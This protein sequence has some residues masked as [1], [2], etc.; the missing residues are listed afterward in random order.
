MPPR[1]RWHIPLARSVV[2][3]FI[4]SSYYELFLAELFPQV[5]IPS[6]GAADRTESYGHLGRGSL[7]VAN[8]SDDGAGSEEKDMRGVRGKIDANEDDWGV[9]FRQTSLDEIKGN[10][11]ILERRI[12]EAVEAA[13]KVAED[14]AAAAA[15]A[16]VAEAAAGT[17]GGEQVSTVS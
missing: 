17:G 4:Q 15:E 13:R 2:P 11:E 8:P 6:S 16:A 3:K 9:R 5:G 7:F 12:S 10:P 14:A 1:A